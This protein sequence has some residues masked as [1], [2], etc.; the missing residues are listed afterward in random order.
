M[1]VFLTHNSIDTSLC[2]SAVFWGEFL[3]AYSRIV[4]NC[5]LVFTGMTRGAG[6]LNLAVKSVSIRA[7][8]DV[9]LAGN[10]PYPMDWTIRYADG[11]E[12]HLALSSHGLAGATL[13]I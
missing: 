11:R 10:R 5:D 13:Q 7:A 6:P 1:R 12:G 3:K 8:H 4:E 9:A 2:D